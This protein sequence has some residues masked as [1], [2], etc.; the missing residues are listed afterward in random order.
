[1]GERMPFG[2]QCFVLR[3]GCRSFLIVLRSPRAPRI[4]EVRGLCEKCSVLAFY[5]EKLGL[6]M[7]AAGITGQR[8]IPSDDAVARNHDGYGIVVIGHPDRPG[9]PGASDR[10][11]NVAIGPGLPIRNAEQFSPDC[12]LK[13]GAVDIEL[14][15]EPRPFSL[16]VLGE[17]FDQFVM[18]WPVG[19]VTFRDSVSKLN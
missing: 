15:L 16:E 7:E 3:H 4:R 17:L 1:M 18:G 10:F 11:R 6:Q 5:R 19:N 8:T 9:S 14:K 13:R 12:L 2:I